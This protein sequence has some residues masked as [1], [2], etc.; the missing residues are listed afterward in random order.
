MRRYLLLVLVVL[1]WTSCSKE[2]ADSQAPDSTPSS[3]STESEVRFYQQEVTP[4]EVKLVEGQD[5]E[6]VDLKKLL[7][8]TPG[9]R[10]GTDAHI[11]ISFREAIV[12]KYKVGSIL[13]DNPFTF[14]PEIKGVARWINRREL[15]FVPHEDLKAGVN[16]SGSISGKLLVGSTRSVDEIEFQFSTAEQE[17]LRFVG[18]FEASDQGGNVV[19]LRGTLSFAQPVDL[20]KISRDLKCVSRV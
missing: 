13:S 18:D 2:E 8:S 20:E 7:I 16:Y 6:P 1:F 4:E 9:K 15:H 19:R 5:I 17:V 12:P 14:S 11:I 10:I 3:E